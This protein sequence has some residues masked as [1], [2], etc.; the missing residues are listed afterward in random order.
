MGRI[1]RNARLVLAFELHGQGKLV[2]EGR[3]F[4]GLGLCRHEL[5]ECVSNAHNIT[6]NMETLQVCQCG[7]LAWDQHTFV[8]ICNSRVNL[9]GGDRVVHGSSSMEGWGPSIS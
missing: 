9:P 6:L 7:L 4:V 3:E 5:I 1:D 2:F 8:H